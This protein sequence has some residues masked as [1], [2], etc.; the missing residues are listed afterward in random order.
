MSR[1][2]LL[3][4]WARWTAGTAL[5]TGGLQSRSAR[6]QQA[7]TEEEPSP[8]DDET[9]SSSAGMTLG[10][11]TYGMKS[12][13][14]ELALAVLAQLG[15]DSVELTVRQ[16]WDADPVPMAAKR[17]ADLGRLLDASGLRLTSLM[18]HL[19]PSQD[20][21]AHTAA[22]D[23]LKRVAALGHDLSEARQPLIQTTLGGGS[24]DT[25]NA[26]Y[27]D[28]VAD[29]VEVCQQAG[30]VLAIKPHRGGGM[31]RPE[32]ARWLI[33]QLDNTP[34]LRMVYDYS[35]YAFREMPLSE[36]IRTALP[37]TAHIAVK[38]AVQRDEQVVF[39]LP[40][41]SGRFDYAPL[42]KQFH[43]GGY[44]G[45]VSCEVSGMVWS[46]RDYD[47]IQAARVCYR[48]M[49]RAFQEAAVPRPK[50]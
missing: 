1:R 39:Q 28:R 31:S 9:P 21:K 35:H 5:L 12:L 24:W 7:P 25:V 17:R 46:Q 43:G 19:Q 42:L 6:G 27:R 30:C 47:P 26:M 16:G 13:T 50:S 48:H 3:E 36:T 15:Y 29:W 40:G 2:A 8:D 32:Q 18:E 33:V 37:V 22:L 14:T 11:S 20:A 44:R 4:R 41:E 23:R 38:D 49:S 45:D 34:W 10:F